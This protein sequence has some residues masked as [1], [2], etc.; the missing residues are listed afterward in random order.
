MSAGPSTYYVGLTE[1]GT[2]SVTGEY[3]ALAST[4]HIDLVR[5][6]TIGPTTYY[7][8]QVRSTDYHGA[9][10]ERAAIYAYSIIT[11][12]NQ[13]F[14]GVDIHWRALVD[15]FLEGNELIGG[16]GQFLKLHLLT[17]GEGFNIVPGFIDSADE[18]G[19]PNSVLVGG[20]YGNS[21]FFITPE[22]DERIEPIW[23]QQVFGSPVTTQIL[24]LRVGAWREYSQLFEFPVTVRSTGYSNS[25]ISTTDLVGGSGVPA[26][27]TAYLLNGDHGGIGARLDSSDGYGLLFA[28]QNLG[29]LAGETEAS[30]S[31]YAAQLFGTPIAYRTFTLKFPNFSYDT[32]ATWT[33]AIHSSAYDSSSLAA[34]SVVGGSGTPVE[35]TVRLQNG[36]HG[37]IL[38]TV[39]NPEGQLW[40]SSGTERYF[41]R[42]IFEA[43]QSVGTISIFG[44]QK[45]GTLVSP[46]SLQIEFPGNVIGVVDTKFLE[47]LSS[48]YVKTTVLTPRPAASGFPAADLR[49]KLLNGNHGGLYMTLVNPEG[50]INFTG[51]LDGTFLIEP[52]ATEVVVHALA[53][54]G[55]TPRR[56]TVLIHI[57]ESWIGPNPVSQSNLRDTVS[58]VLR[59][60]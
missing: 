5:L 25:S 39:S 18:T 57:S 11:G 52:G 10:F 42:V 48:G 1:S 8:W 13:A 37:G 51:S 9:L 58:V 46:Q 20:S 3:Y 21:Q 26:T 12:E 30:T 6:I 55:S 47:V 16:S 14:I 15:A 31:V 56:Q 4:G 41:G 53:L 17:A 19:T 54:S 22:E 45:F 23:A 28:N 35:L 44:R 50:G 33:I 7:S 2:A 43:G 36:N 40:S 59:G 34:S 32:F 60:K 27:F 24:Q 49:I 38:A 29:F